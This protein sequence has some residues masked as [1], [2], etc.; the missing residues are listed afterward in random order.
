[1]RPEL[2]A[3]AAFASF[4]LTPPPYVGPPP[5]SSV[6][7]AVRRRQLLVAELPPPCSFHGVAPL[8][9]RLTAAV[10]AIFVDPLS[11][12]LPSGRPAVVKP[13]ASSVE[14][15]GAIVVSSPPRGSARGVRMR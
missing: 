9:L 8:P 10:A 5:P 4:P 3:T 1:M 11:L 14:Q 13:A 12:P 6:Y 7:A 15:K 2:V